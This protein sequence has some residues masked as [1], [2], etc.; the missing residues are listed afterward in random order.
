MTESTL[1]FVCF[2]VEVKCT[3]VEFGRTRKIPREDLDNVDVCV[4]RFNEKAL[5]C[6]YPVAEE[7]LVDVCILVIME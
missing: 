1:S 3:L 7:V 5:A 2:Y 4:R 6:Y